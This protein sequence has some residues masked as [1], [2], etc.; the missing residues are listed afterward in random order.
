MK[1]RLLF[2]LM[3]IS[4]ISIVAIH[5]D[6]RAA[7]DLDAVI[8]ESS[9]I[10]HVE[11]QATEQPIETDVTTESADLAM[12]GIYV[13]DPGDLYQGDIS[14]EKNSLMRVGSGIEVANAINTP[15]VAISGN[16]IGL[17]ANQ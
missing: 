15:N 3:M 1:L 7:T 12:T 2:S 16:R 11:D 13:G 4:Q 9:L 6:A 14:I 5:R 17:V 10:A 8:T